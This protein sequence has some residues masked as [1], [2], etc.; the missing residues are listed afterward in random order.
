MAVL[1][2]AMLVPLSASTAAYADS[3]AAS[4]NPSASTEQSGGQESYEEG[5]AIV[6]YHASGASKGSTGTLV[7]QSEDDPLASAGFA[8]SQSWDLSPADSAAR[9]SADGALSIQSQDGGTIASGSDV[10]IALVKHDDMSTDDLVSQLTSLDFV[11]CASP[12][13]RYTIDTAETSETTTATTAGTSTAA[14]TSNSTTN[15][16][17]QSLS[18]QST[19]LTKDRLSSL[20]WYLTSATAGIDEQAAL[21]AEAAGTVDNVVA[22]LDTGV[23]YNNPDLVNQMWSDPGTIGLGLAGSHGYNGYNETYDPMPGS[24]Y[25]IVGY[26]AHGTHCAGVIA[27]Q[28]NNNEGIAGVAGTGSHTKIMALRTF[29]DNGTMMLESGIVSCYEYLVQARMA[30]VNVV[31][32]NNSWGGTSMSFYDPVLDYLVNQAGKAGVLSCFAAANSNQNAS[33]YQQTVTLESPY[34]IVVASSNAQNGISSFSNYDATAVDVAAPG[35]NVISTVPVASYPAW[36][37]STISL[38]SNGTSGMRYHTTIDEQLTNA[39][40]SGFTAVLKAGGTVL[41]AE[42]QKALTYTAAT[43]DGSGLLPTGNNALKL[44]IDFDNAALVAELEK[45][46]VGTDGV[47][48]VVSWN[49]DN[50]GLFKGSNAVAADYAVNLAVEGIGL[51]DS[52]AVYAYARLYSADKNLVYP[53]SYVSYKNDTLNQGGGYMTGMDTQSSTL[54]AQAEVTYGWQGW[55]PSGKLSCLLT[56]YCVGRVASTNAADTTP[57]AFTPYAYMSGTSMATPV[58]T[59]SIAELASLRAYA[60]CTPLQLRGIICGGTVPLSSSAKDH[61]GN[62]K[63]IASDGRFTFAAAL[64]SASVNAN[65]WSITT[66]GNQVTVHGYALDGAKLYVDDASH[67]TPVATGTSEDSITFSADESLFDGKAHR[68]DVV[69]GTTGRSYNASYV[70]PVVS[71]DSLVHVHD[72]PVT[73]NSAE[74]VLIS[75]PTCLFFAN[76]AGDYLY[77]CTD[78]SDPT[79]SWKELATPH[80]P[81]TSVSASNLGL[82]FAYS[83]GRLFAF[84]V[85]VNDASQPELDYAVYDITQNTWSG[86]EKAG[87]AAG[88]SVTLLSADTLNGTVFVYMDSQAIVGTKSIFYHDLFTLPAGSSTFSAI[89]SSDE[90]LPQALFAAQ[91]TLHGL[92]AKSVSGGLTPALVDVDVSTLAVDA[93]GAISGYGTS[94]NVVSA[95]SLLSKIQAPTGNGLVILGESEFGLGDAQLVDTVSLTATKLGSFGL[96]SADGLTTNAAYMYGGRLYISCT[97]HTG[98]SST[99]SC[100]KTSVGLYTL[101]QQ[102]AERVASLDATQTAAAEKDGTAAVADWRN[103]P[104]TSLSVRRGDTV[105]WTAKPDAGE[106]F[107]GWYDESGNLVSAEAS[108]AATSGDA[109]TLTARFSAAPASAAG[110][111]A[112]SSAMPSTGD[113]LSP[114][115]PAALAPLGLVALGASHLRRRQVRRNSIA[116]QPYTREQ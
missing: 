75:S 115:V 105:T 52:G 45:L 67:A 5:Q 98:T 86:F 38:G 77:G 87:V 14:A 92:S 42:A 10:R 96:T 53:Y 16:V 43:A 89:S 80:T 94:S 34:A 103:T 21:S 13:Y 41:S 25:G 46:D 54:R 63:H 95:V 27:A 71:A 114:T 102:A 8:A 93:R 7:A 76:S 44:T 49:V 47:T 6:I 116:Q 64:D 1:L 20:Q 106:T 56:N 111:D 104:G 65:T 113:P 58:I 37:N 2:A 29:D 55:T 78:P 62:E 31:A 69:D 101:P 110:A 26:A 84:A 19:G 9:A 100:T 88:T 23:D 18:A 83:N 50:A 32:V 3:A 79:S 17:T 112:G 72:L 61:S 40:T 57:V 59:G 91:G 99:S 97:D 39:S 35:S 51:S 81:W 22:V 82:I 24:N 11:E 85:R 68:F 109:T 48:A 108:Y 33:Y 30:G 90:T 36:F 66:S 70:T 107:T 73:S 12:N 74:G 28:A 15:P 60:N 4:A